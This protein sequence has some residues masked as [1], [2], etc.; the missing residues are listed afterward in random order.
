MF[1]YWG[2]RGISRLVHD[3][4]DAAARRPDLDWGLSIAR[5]NDQF[6][7]F[8]AFGPRVHVIDTFTSSTG[9]VTGAWRLPAL[10]RGLSAE[11]ARRRAR[12]V[13]SL[14]PHVWSWA[15][16]RGARQGGAGY[17]TI[18]HDAVAHPGDATGLVQQL[19]L[20]DAD[21][22]DR[23]FTLSTAV[24]GQLANSGRVRR[25]RIIPLFHP[26]RPAPTAV[27][28]SAPAPGDPWRL[29]FFGRVLRYKGLPL[30]VEAVRLLRAGGH[31]VHLS[32]I[33]EGPLGE[34][35][36]E[37][38]AL[39]AIIVNEWVDEAAFDAALASHHVMVLPYVESSQ[40]GPAAAA[41]GSALPM[42]VTPVGGLKE[43]V[44]DGVTGLVATEVDAPSVAAALS[45][46]MTEPGLYAALVAELAAKRHAR[47]TDAF[48]AAILEHVDASAPP[49]HR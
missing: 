38:A 48:V 7:S 5:Q 24:A 1:V 37:L 9:A 10:A 46:L 44:E 39:D 28:R 32:V 26:T 35:A 11:V 3:I 27:P 8:A 42:V 31:R 14:M 43:Q 47:S 21:R 34:L 22:A 33:G 23:V 2:R 18:I 16:A 12:H 49:R 40:S 30:L 4:V 45:R 13:V 29:L 17:H 25:D 15:T 20:R 36:P 41:L 19:L 6:D